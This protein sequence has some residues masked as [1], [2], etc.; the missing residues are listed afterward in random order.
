MLHGGERV[1]TS[2]IYR[3]VHYLHPEH[4]GDTVLLAGQT[5]PR[6]TACKDVE[7]I[8]VMAAPAVKAVHDLNSAQKKEEPRRSRLKRLCI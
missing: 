8:F 2:G 7:Y 1:A 5:F 4:D 6:C 3:A